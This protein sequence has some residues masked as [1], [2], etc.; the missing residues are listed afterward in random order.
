MMKIPVTRD[1]KPRHG[2]KAGSK[3][4]SSPKG[5]PKFHPKPRRPSLAR[6]HNGGP[7]NLG[8]SEG[9]NRRQVEGWTKRY[10]AAKTDEHPELE[11]VITWL[12]DNIPPESGTSLIHNDY[13]K[14]TTSCSTPKT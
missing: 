2:R 6:L 1:Q 5:L 10:F 7:R 12:G 4:P 3:I 9:Y 11:S 13:K 14:L 8:H